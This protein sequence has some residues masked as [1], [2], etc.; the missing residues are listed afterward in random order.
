MLERRYHCSAF[1]KKSGLRAERIG[2]FTIA[3][4]FLSGCGARLGLAY[5]SA[6]DDPANRLPEE[7]VIHTGSEAANS[8]SDV[9]QKEVADNEAEYQAWLKARNSG[10]AEYQEF[11]EFREWLEYKKTQESL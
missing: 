2:L 3:V 7:I 8:Q 10:S 6:Q 1:V 9:S 5:D 11:L 4:V